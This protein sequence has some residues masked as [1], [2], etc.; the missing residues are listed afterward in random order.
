MSL[1]E[2][3]KQRV[4]LVDLVSETIQL[5]KSG[6]NYKA[7]C[8]F[9]Q[10]KTPSFYVFPDRQYWHCFGACAEGGDVFNYVQKR[11]GVDFRDALRTLAARAGLEFRGSSASESRAEDQHLDRL[12]AANDAAAA[13][14]QNL[15]L[16]TEQ[17]AE[18]LKY[19]QE[20]GLDDRVLRD[21]QLGFAPGRGALIDHLST[22]GFAS[23]EIIEAGLAVEN[24]S[25]VYDRFHD[26]IMFPIRDERGRVVGLGGRT[27]VD[28]VAKYLN[29][30]QT[31]LFDKSG[32]LYA[33]DRARDAIRQADQVVVVEGYMDVI[34]AHQFGHRD[35]IASMG[36]ALTEKQV[37]TLKR[38]TR[39]IILALDADAAGAEATMRGIEVATAGAEKEIAAVITPGSNAFVRLQEQS[40][41]EIRIL[42]IPEGKDPDELIRKE[43]GRWDELVASAK[44]VIDHLLDRLP[45][46]YDVSDPREGG[47]AARE[48]IPTLAAINDAVVRDRYV[49]RLAHLIHVDESALREQLAR[50]SAARARVHRVD[51]PAPAKAVRRSSE[52]VEEYLLALL[53]RFPVLRDSE[54]PEPNALFTLSVHQG[55]YELWLQ[56]PDNEGLAALVPEELLPDYERVLSRYVPPLDNA[57]ADNALNETIWKL[58]Q[59]NVRRAKQVSA[60]AIA[61]IE[62]AAR[63]AGSQ[64]SELLAML[65]Q[66]EESL[67]AEDLDQL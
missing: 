18:S 42:T 4:D 65:K 50:P 43:P 34:A 9:H 61:E 1:A 14:Y 19:L 66:S 17:G 7:N 29:T 26:R 32:L 48:I 25:G 58:Q 21:F 12:R 56:A 31:P 44:P 39:R 28:D 67:G 54:I 37:A 38:Y 27:T 11:D 30:P 62:A 41:T 6:K 51:P 60:D 10:E 35:V 24:E 2:E 8:P 46:R 64:F 33:L 23:A 53:V 57:S 63:Q 59:R 20:R 36:T 45:E 40:A 3:V 55:L 16:Q 15:L 49:Q 52:P 47:R 5:Q 22:R 13:F